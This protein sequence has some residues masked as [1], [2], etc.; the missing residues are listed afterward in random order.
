MGDRRGRRRH[1]P[2]RK[3]RAD[4]PHLPDPFLQAEVS[5]IH[6]DTNGSFV[7]EQIDGVRDVSAIGALVEEHFGEAAHPTYERLSKFFQI[8]ESYKF[9]EWK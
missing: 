6:L 1:A 9:V 8:L 7:W 2:R 5:R 3:P 4:E